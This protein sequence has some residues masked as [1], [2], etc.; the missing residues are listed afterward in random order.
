VQCIND[1]C[2]GQCFPIEHSSQG[3]QGDEHQQVMGGSARVWIP[4]VEIIKD[5]HSRHY[6]SNAGLIVKLNFIL[7]EM[8]KRFRC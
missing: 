1:V 8:P 4:G 7:L 2:T 5:T 3:H 6:L